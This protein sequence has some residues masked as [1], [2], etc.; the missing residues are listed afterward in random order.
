M[1]YDPDVI[2]YV[3]F[4]VPRMYTDTDVRY[5]YINIDT[6]D[7]PLQYNEGDSYISVYCTIPAAR[8]CSCLGL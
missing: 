2:M 8:C 1:Y 4:Q 6:L 3:P 7:G 5:K